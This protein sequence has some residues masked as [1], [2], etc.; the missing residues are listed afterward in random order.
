MRVVDAGMRAE[1]A[2]LKCFRERTVSVAGLKQGA[3]KWHRG[4]LSPYLLPSQVTPVGLLQY[5]SV[6]N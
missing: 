4:W 1:A 6:L 5:G 2:E 3:V